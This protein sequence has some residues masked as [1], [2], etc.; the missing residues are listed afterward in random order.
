MIFVLCLLAAV[1]FIL[2]HSEEEMAETGVVHYEDDQLIFFTNPE[3]P[4]IGKETTFTFTAFDENGNPVNNAL[5]HVTLENDEDHFIFLET[6][7]FSQAGTF[8]FNYGIYDGAPT[9]ATIHVEPTAAS[10]PT[11]EP[12]EKAYGFAATAHN[13][14]FGAKLIALSV[15][16]AA[17]LVGFALGVGARKLFSKP[18]SAE[19]EHH[20]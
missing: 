6:D 17:L 8:S 9:I 7:L 11:F 5:A 19:G 16:L 1:P 2:A 20:E 14:P 3:V 10:S 13:P 15:M 4:D 18:E 12:I